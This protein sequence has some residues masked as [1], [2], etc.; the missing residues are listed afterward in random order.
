MITARLQGGLGNQ[1]F[2]FAMA[3]A[4]AKRLGVELQLDVSLLKGRRK[5]QLDQWH[6]FC[7][8]TRAPLPDE[9]LTVT[10]KTTTVNESGM[11]YNPG[12]LEHIKDGAVINGYWQT[13]KYFSDFAS[14]IRGIFHPRGCNSQ[15]ENLNFIDWSKKIEQED[16]SVFVHVRHGDYL[17][18]PHHSYHG[19]LPLSYYKSAMD[20][21]RGLS[22][23]PKFFVFSDDET[24]VRQNLIGK[25]V[26]FVDIKQEAHA[27]SLMSKCRHAV[28]ANSSFSWWGAWLG[29]G[30]KDGIHIAPKQWFASSKEDTRDIIPDLWDAIDVVPQ[31]TKREQEPGRKILFAVNSWDEDARRGCHQAIRETWGKDVAPADLRFFVPRVPNHPLLADEV[32]VDVPRDYDY[33]CREVVEI[34]RWSLNEGY[35]FTFLVSNDVFVLSQ[36]LL[37]SGFE[38][39]DYSGFFHEQTPLGEMATED[40]ECTFKTEAGYGRL[41]KLYNWAD[42]GDGRM[43]SRKAAEII[44]ASPD[45]AYWLA[46]D[47]IFI[48]QALG[49]RIGDG[50]IRVW[51]IGQHK[52][53]APNNGITWHFKN[54]PEHRGIRYEPNAGWLQKMYKEHT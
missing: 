49:P 35:D 18:E 16:E 34:L 36:K 27:I 20:Y 5:Y 30:K 8:L 44:V 38:Q 51:N 25:D 13:E 21:I 12:L 42:G 24:W 37:K 3:Y 9:Y 41:R 39:Y 1:M 29:Y 6:R 50:E 14:E 7:P 53:A 52:D 31:A 15:Q 4:Q 46:A 43:L 22:R 19:I 32:F 45:A 47:D 33:V 48:G 40:Y 17:I 2:Q 10:G 28:I 11:P 23:A 26:T 54:Y